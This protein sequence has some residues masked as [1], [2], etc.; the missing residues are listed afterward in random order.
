[1]GVIA[2]YSLQVRSRRHPLERDSGRLFWKQS[3]ILDLDI[4]AVEAEL[5]ASVPSAVAPKTLLASP[6]APTQSMRS[7]IA[8]YR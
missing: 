8:F 7:L 1:M 3:Q 4:A 2:C 6:P 5:A